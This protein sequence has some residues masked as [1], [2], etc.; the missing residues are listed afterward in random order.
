MVA[1]ASELGKAEISHAGSALVVWAL[2][3][4]RIWVWSEFSVFER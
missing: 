3:R 4:G 2:V 1:S